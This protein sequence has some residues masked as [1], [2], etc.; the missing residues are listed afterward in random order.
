MHFPKNICC[1]PGRLGE[2]QMFSG[3]HIYMP[4]QFLLSTR[5]KFVFNVLQVPYLGPHT[6]Y[7]VT[8]LLS[9]TYPVAAA[10]CNFRPDH[11]LP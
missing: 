9:C 8:L 2:Q 3:K 5:Q 7:K 6:L 1:S 4:L 11:L 10:L